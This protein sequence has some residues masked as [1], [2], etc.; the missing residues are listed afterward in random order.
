[1]GKHIK[2]Y[3]SIPYNI[4]KDTSEMTDAVKSAKS[5]IRKFLWGKDYKVAYDSPFEAW[6]YNDETGDSITF[7][8]SDSAGKN[9]VGVNRIR[10]P[11]TADGPLYIFGNNIQNMALC[12]AAF[13]MPGY[14]RT[15]DCIFEYSIACMY[16]RP[17]ELCPGADDTISFSADNND[18]LRSAETE[19]DLNTKSEIIDRDD[20]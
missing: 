13:F 11:G 6:N 1:M 10:V 15:T 18:N 3:L 12:D 20:I 7:Y 16:N 2:V 19:T 5:Y 4:Y 17:V 9:S 8:F 14:D